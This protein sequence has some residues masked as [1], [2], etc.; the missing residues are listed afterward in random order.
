MYSTVNRSSAYRTRVLARRDPLCETVFVEDVFVVAF[1]LRNEIFVAILRE[2]DRAFK[3]S[4]GLA[5][6]QRMVL[7]RR[8]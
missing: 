2:A 3:V 1:Q 4:F 5:F 6:H 8:Q 7:K